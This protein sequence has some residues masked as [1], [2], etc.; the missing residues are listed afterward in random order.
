MVACEITSSLLQWLFLISNAFDVSG[1]RYYWK[2]CHRSVAVICN[3]TGARYYRVHC[4]IVTPCYVIL[5]TLITNIFMSVIRKC[6]A[7]PNDAILVVSLRNSG[8]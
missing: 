2:T 1:N 8:R 5:D 6:E 3:V 4:N 7:T